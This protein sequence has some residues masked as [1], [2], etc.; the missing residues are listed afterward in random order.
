MEIEL[1]SSGSD[2]AVTYDVRQDLIVRIY[3]RQ[4]WIAIRNPDTLVKGTVQDPFDKRTYSTKIH[5]G[6]FLVL[7]RKLEEIIDKRKIKNV[8]GA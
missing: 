7:E 8:V 1:Y 4:Q 5:E 6:G 3:F 2:F